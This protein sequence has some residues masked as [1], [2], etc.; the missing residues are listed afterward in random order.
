[1]N[2]T[3]SYSLL[4]G[5]RNHETRHSMWRMVASHAHRATAHEDEHDWEARPELEVDRVDGAAN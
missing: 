4:R 3:V 2:A 1:M 5:Q